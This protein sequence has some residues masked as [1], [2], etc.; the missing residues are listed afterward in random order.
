M[1]FYID[2]ILKDMKYR[3][4]KINIHLLNL[5]LPY[6]RNKILYTLVVKHQV[7]QN[8]LNVGVHLICLING[9]YCFVPILPIFGC[10]I[11]LWEEEAHMLYKI[12][13]TTCNLP[14]EEILSAHFLKTFSHMMLHMRS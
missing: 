14:R 11:F 8:I 1:E 6:F 2:L 13:S 5:K 3:F 10:L 9:L 7:N 12:R 4:K